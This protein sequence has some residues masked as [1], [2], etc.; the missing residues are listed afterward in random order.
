MFCVLSPLNRSLLP[1]AKRYRPLLGLVMLVF[2]ARAHAQAT[3]PNAAAE[4]SAR[5][6]VQAGDKISLKVYRELELSDSSVMV[7]A[8]GS[9]VL[10]RIGRLQATGLTISALTDTVRARYARFLRNPAV[11]LVVLRRVAVNG[12]VMKP[13]VYYVDVATTLRDVIARA[14]G[15]T[16]DGSDGRVDIVRRGQR[17]RVKNWQDDF[18]LASDLNSGDQ[19]IVGRRPWFSRNA[20]SAISS[21]GLLVSLYVT[22]RR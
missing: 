11:E 20:F 15:I 8:D 1:L 3:D 18:T 6:T 7:N 14:G 9:I 4:R 12:E 19:V 17:T 5:A 13:N 22:L 2:A 10:A 16:P 21:F